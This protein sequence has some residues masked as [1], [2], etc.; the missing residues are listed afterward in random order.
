MPL[1]SY[2]KAFD[3]MQLLISKINERVRIV[4]NG[5]AF[6]IINSCAD[7]SQGYYNY[8]TPS[9]DA[10]I[11]YIIMQLKSAM[12]QS[13]NSQDEISAIS[14]LLY[15]FYDIRFEISYN[16]QVSGKQILEIWSNGLYSSNPR[17]TVLTRWGLK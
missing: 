12:S 1:S 17:D 2:A 11:L 8:S 5:F 14:D 3:L 7:G 10:N 15:E 4:Q 13:Q 16:T 9:R 6:C